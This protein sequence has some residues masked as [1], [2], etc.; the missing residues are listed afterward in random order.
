M[1]ATEKVTVP[2]PEPLDPEVMVTKPL[3]GTAFQL[4]LPAAVTVKLPLPP[5][6]GKFWLVEPSEVTQAV[7]SKNV[8]MLG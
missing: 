1:F 3:L 2:F 6:L 7:P 8:A 5:V 4:Q